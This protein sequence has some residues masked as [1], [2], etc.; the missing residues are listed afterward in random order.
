MKP[1]VN[2]TAYEFRVRAH[3]S[4]GWGPYSAPVP[5]TPNV[6]GAAPGAPTGLTAIPGDKQV[7][8]SWDEPSGGPIT[9]Y[10]VQY[11]I[12]G[13]VW[14]TFPDGISTDRSATV[15]PLVN[16]SA[17]E[18]RVR[19]H[20]SVGWGTW[21]AA[22]PGTPNVA[23]AV[24]GAPPGLTAVRGDKQVSLSWGLPS[25]APITDY[26]VQYRLV[27]G[28][29]AGFPDGTSTDRSATVKPLVNGS[30][31]EFRVRAHNSFG[32]GPYSAA[33]PG[34]PNPAGAKPGV[35]TGL[36]AVGGLKQVVL[37]WDLPSGAPDDYGVQYRVIGGVWTLFAD[38]TSTD[39]SATVKPLA[40]G[41]TYEFR[42]RAHNPFGWGT[43]SAAVPGTTNPAGT[44][45][46]AP[47][48]LTAAPGD[49]QVVLDWEA[50]LVG[51]PFDDYGVQ[52]RVVGGDWFT[53]PDG[54]SANLSATVKAVVNEHHL[55]VP[56]A[57]T[58][59][60]RMGPVYGDRPH[61]P[62]RPARG[63]Q[64][65]RT[66]HRGHRGGVEPHPDLGGGD[67]GSLLRVLL[68]H[69]QRQRLHQLDQH[70]H[71][72]LGR[73]T[74][75]AASTTYYWQVR[76]V[77][78]CGTTYANGGT[79][80]SF[81]TVAATAA[82]Q[83]DRSGE[84]GYRGVVHPDPDLGGGNGAA[85]YEYCYDT[86]NDCTCWTSVGANT[87]VT[88]PG[89]DSSHLLLAGAGEQRD[90]HHLCQRRHLVE[91]HH[92][93][94]LPEP[95]T[96]PARPTGRPGWSSNPTLTW[97]A[98]REP[99]TTS[100]AT[101]PATDNA[102]LGSWTS[103]GATTSRPDRAGGRTPPT[104]GRCGP[105]TLRHHL[106]QRRHRTGPSPPARRRGLQ[107]DRTGGSGDRRGVE[108]DPDLGCGDGSSLLR[109]LLSTPAAPPAPAGPARTSTSALSAGLR[110]AHEHHLLL[111]GAGHQ[112]LGTT[113]ANSGTGWT[114]HHRCPARGLQ[115]DRSDQRGHRGVVN[116]TL[117][118]GTSTGPP[119][120]STATTPAAAPA[121]A[122]AAA[123]GRAPAPASAHLPRSRGTYYWQVRATNSFSPTS[124]TYANSDT[125]WNFTTVNPV[126]VQ[127]PTDLAIELQRDWDGWGG[128]Y[129][130]WLFLDWTAS[131]TPG[132]HYHVQ[133]CRWDIANNQCAS[134]WGSTTGTSST[135]LYTSQVDGAYAYGF[136]VQAH[137][138]SPDATSD[139]VI[140]APAARGPPRTC[141]STTTPVTTR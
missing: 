59:L 124:T 74:G 46:S 6:A 23:G 99:T 92:R 57:G 73:L 35:P 17:Y 117:T 21:S 44:K 8:L 55:R 10:G 24:P 123:P 15:K 118:W 47:R 65:D 110:P 63:F 90:R 71:Q 111:A 83:Q 68:R 5:G 64:Q 128:H 116:P 51:A 95:S 16:G 86:T 29:W 49:K 141:I 103:T 129:D 70:R 31:Y 42:V 14:A 18:F 140:C 2:G 4:V 45:P 48:N 96:R 97:A 133:Y 22:V 100:T 131:A 82:L 105:S 135:Y 138:T 38:G 9:D 98:Q 40:D 43:W 119:P 58:Q 25:G 62:G 56:S 50:P 134:G 76:A 67:G 120:T 33:V 12:V 37:T 53:Y 3:N 19:A 34:T 113:Y 132:V 94:A 109:V 27:G 32:W 87:S 130:Y 91:L 1:L 85:S 84:R 77:N 79:W 26:G 139:W 81:T 126:T 107:Q 28:V 54:V 121:P 136:R 114:L 75:L 7:V 41:T 137:Q 66:G 39:R 115:Q 61:N 102:L 11:R 78:G 93:R 69:H 30:A 101:T 106:R 20:N 104:T 80:W 60:G 72:P 52:Y 122:P 88:L 112:R 108:P 125:V 36:M 127:P 13:D 89:S